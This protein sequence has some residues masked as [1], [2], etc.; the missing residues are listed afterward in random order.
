MP[1][2]TAGEG[3]ISETYFS[4]LAEKGGC[5]GETVERFDYTVE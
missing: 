3:L 1:R 4:G 5:G 2:A